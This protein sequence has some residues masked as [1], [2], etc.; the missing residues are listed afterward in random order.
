VREYVGSESD[1][2]VRIIA[3]GDALN[4]AEAAAAVAQVRSE[5]AR[6]RELEPVLHALAAGMQEVQ[7]VNFL[8]CGYR[9]RRGELQVVKYRKSKPQSSNNTAGEPLTR[10][11]L[12]H[13]ADRANRGD[14]DAA[15]QLRKALRNH[16]EIMREVGDLAKHA[17]RSLIGLIGDGNLVLSESVQ[18]QAEELRRSLQSEAG[19]ETLERLLIDHIVICWLELHYVRTA[20]AQPQQHK[21]DAGFWESRL[22]RANARFIGATKELATLR[23]LLGHAD[24]GAPTLV[25][26]TAHPAPTGSE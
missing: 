5:Q 14:R 26:T 10:E 6:Y 1:P 13:L 4:R 23:S 24:P 20:A 16:P 21:T 2:V 9:R 12:E 17:Q 7:E 15:G 11:L 25:A 18:I 22:D 19:D 3:Q 8:V